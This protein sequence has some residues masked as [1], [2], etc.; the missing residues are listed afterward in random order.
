MRHMVQKLLL[1]HFGTPILCRNVAI[2][3]LLPCKNNNIQAWLMPAL[4]AAGLKKVCA[5]GGACTIDV[6]RQKI[7]AKRQALAGLPEQRWHS[8]M[9]RSVYAAQ[10]S[11]IQDTYALSLTKPS[12]LHCDASQV[13]AVLIVI[14]RPSTLGCRALSIALCIS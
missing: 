14:P 3:R 5:N 11:L 12:K 13:S 2:S 10:S 7:A 1:I 6:L 9:V 4:T 8:A